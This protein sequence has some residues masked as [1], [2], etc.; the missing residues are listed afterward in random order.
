MG[1][2]PAMSGPLDGYRIV[3]LTAMITGPLATMILGDQGAEI[4]KVE[5][6]GG[7]DVMRHLGTQRGGVSTLFAAC[8]RSK[9]SI[10]VNL[11]E[12]TGRALVR[13][14]AARADVFVQNFRPGVIERL[15]LAEPV[16]RARHPG[17]VYVSLSAFG[18]DGP[19]A[20]RPAYDHILQALTGAPY[21]QGGE[22]GGRPEYVRMAWCDKV[23]AL[24]AAQAITAALLARERGR[25]GQHLR[26]SMLDASLA[27]LWPDGYANHCLLESEGVT[28]LP[29]LAHTYRALELRDGFVALAVITDAQWE[30]VLRATGLGALRGDPRF[31]TVG[32]RLAHLAE[33]ASELEAGA[34]GLGCDEMLVRLAAQ[35]VPC[36]P[37]LRLEDVPRFE[38]V[39]ASQALLETHH[40]A[41][42]RL[43]EPRPPVR[44]EAT[45]AAIARPA[46]GLGEHGEEVLRELGL[47]PA[48]IAALRADRVIS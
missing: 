27:F 30:G 16:L 9:R 4:V 23:T 7:G 22:A 44:F 33:L 45:P 48:R 18:S 34:R 26:L 32:A 31:A 15:G 38:Q 42:G 28:K 17:L 39:V 37:I 11:R 41:L 35:D 19:Y 46:P 47:E 2:S 40:P 1:Y 43:R 13:D 3:D 5:P 29:S 14:L 10:V 24:V 36:A 25:G 8:N 20:R 12:E 21:V 6:P